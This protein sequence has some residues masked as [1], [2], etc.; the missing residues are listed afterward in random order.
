[1]T[2]RG[3]Q[4]VADTQKWL[5]WQRDARKAELER[6]SWLRRDVP[7]FTAFYERLPRLEKR[8]AA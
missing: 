8:E 2:T 3:A 6:W 5:S 7:G 4:H 1:M